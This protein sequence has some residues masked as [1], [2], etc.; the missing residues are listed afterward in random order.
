M[1]LPFISDTSDFILL[2]VLIFAVVIGRYALIAGIF[3]AVFYVWFPHRWK[4]RK[5]ATKDYKQNQFRKEFFWSSLTSIL[6]ALAGSILYVLWQNG[7]TKIYVQFDE[8]PI[9]WMPLSLVIAMLLHETY[10][11]WL[12]RWMHLPKIFP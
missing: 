11:Y 2:T 4:Q 1:E 6:F 5:I 9:W 10:Y 3:Y 8:Y 7:H 12:H